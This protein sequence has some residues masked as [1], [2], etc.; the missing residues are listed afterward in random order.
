M[1]VDTIVAASSI[2]CLRYLLTLLNAKHLITYKPFLSKVLEQVMVPLTSFDEADYL[3]L[4]GGLWPPE[5]SMSVLFL[6]KALSVPQTLL[7]DC[8]R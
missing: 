6:S 8:G 1:E 7:Q 2:C 4:E 5:A 3:I